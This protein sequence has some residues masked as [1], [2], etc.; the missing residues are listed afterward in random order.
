MREE[1]GSRQQMT[2]IWVKMLPKLSYSRK[3]AKLRGPRRSS[4]LRDFADCGWG[5][6][7]QAHCRLQGMLGNVVLPGQSQS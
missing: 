1:V 4:E 6:N 2:I 3:E 5:G 7:K